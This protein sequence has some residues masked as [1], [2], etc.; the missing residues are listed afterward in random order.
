MQTFNPLISTMQ[1]FSVLL[2]VM[3]TSCN[4]SLQSTEDFEIGA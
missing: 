2:R 3:Y 4:F 1:D